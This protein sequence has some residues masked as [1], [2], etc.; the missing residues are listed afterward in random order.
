MKL[1]TFM[2]LFGISAAMSSSMLYAKM[3]RS[4]C[5]LSEA[6]A[7]MIVVEDLHLNGL[8][9]RFLG[10]ARPTGDCRYDFSYAD[11]GEGGEA[12]DER[13][14]LEYSVVRDWSQGLSLIKRD[15]SPLQ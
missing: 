12:A 11:D 3:V 7:R 5:G 10:R 13:T 6:Q 4:D 14:M 1:A 2:T 8:C 9:E 15:A